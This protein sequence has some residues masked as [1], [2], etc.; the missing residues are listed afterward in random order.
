MPNPST[1]KIALNETPFY[2]LT[3]RCVQNQYGAATI[4]TQKSGC[5]R[6]PRSK[7][8]AV[9]DH[10]ADQGSKSWISDCLP[11]QTCR[12]LVLTA[13]SLNNKNRVHKYDNRTSPAEKGGLAIG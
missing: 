3:Y 2:H 4:C 1:K 7:K 6:S 9:Q 10:P 11:R 13:Q 5:P 12:L 8:V